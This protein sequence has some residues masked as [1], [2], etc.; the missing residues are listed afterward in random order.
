MDI[1]INGHQTHIFTS[2]APFNPDHHAVILL[3]GAGHD[4]SVWR[5]QTRYLAHHGFSVFAPDLPGHGRSRGPAL[6]Q[7]DSMA[8]WLITMMDQCNIS[9][10]TLVGHSMGALISM[11][12]SARY[13]G[14]VSQLVLI[15]A[16]AP[17]PVAPF[18]L[19]AAATECHRAY[20]M[21]NHWSYS[22]KHQIGRS[23]IPGMWMTGFN[24]R[25]MERQPPGVLLADLQACN[26]WT[27][28]R[29][30]IKNIH[31]PTLLVCGQNDQMT[32][33]LRS[34][35]LRTH[36]SN[37]PGGATVLTL[38]DAGHALMAEAPQAVTAALYSFLP[39]PRLK[40]HHL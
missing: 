40:T 7:I 22:F 19:E 36:L 12:A 34:E 15:G 5:Y 21:I 38:P 25:L 27:D 9:R 20:R 13:S 33:P 4:H 28:T 39:K 23:S 35:S 11:V 17:M 10:A 37:V 16:A 26:T 2:S 6:N 14:R 24:M 29:D 3:H 18:L 1:P 31:C 30:E 32:P 8:A